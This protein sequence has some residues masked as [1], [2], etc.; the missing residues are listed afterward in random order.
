M[1]HLKCVN[2]YQYV[3]ALLTAL[4]LPEQAAI[5]GGWIP[6]GQNAHKVVALPYRY[7][8]PCDPGILQFGHTVQLLLSWKF[9]ARLVYVSEFLIPCTH[10]SRPMPAAG[11]CQQQ[12]QL[13]NFPCRTGSI[14]YS[15]LRR[16]RLWTAASDGT[17]ETAAAIETNGQVRPDDYRRVSSFRIRFPIPILILIP[18]QRQIQI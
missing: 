11:S 10:H 15:D 16:R 13:E 5:A 1:N 8:V 7:A 3:P 2:T 12:V 6:G 4:V 9:I 17:N 14:R 18:I